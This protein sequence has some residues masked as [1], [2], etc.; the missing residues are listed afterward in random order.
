MLVI[1]YARLDDPLGKDRI[2]SW[3]VGAY[4]IGV[5]LTISVHLLICVP[6]YDLKSTWL[7]EVALPKGRMIW[8][9]AS[10][11]CLMSLS[12]REDDVAHINF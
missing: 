7:A 8:A 4:R 10:S 3:S 1:G 2:L 6:V 11:I 5:L 12:I 9:T